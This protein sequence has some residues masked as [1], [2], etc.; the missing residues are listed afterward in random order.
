VDSDKFTPPVSFV[1][2]EESRLQGCFLVWLFVRIQVYKTRRMM[3][4]L[5]LRRGHLESRFSVSPGYNITVSRTIGHSIGL[6]YQPMKKA[7]VSCF[8]LPT[9]TQHTTTTHLCTIPSIVTP[10]LYNGRRTLLK[11]HRKRRYAS[12]LVKKV[13]A[14]S[15]STVCLSIQA[16]D[17]L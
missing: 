13:T 11:C 3:T 1:I 17:D 4:S 16:L 14:V 9:T 5:Y 8:L 7:S 6:I 10:K 15:V 2:I 12:K